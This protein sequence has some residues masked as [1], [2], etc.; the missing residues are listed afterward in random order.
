METYLSLLLFNLTFYF[1]NSPFIE[2]LANAEALSRLQ[3]TEV[4]KNVNNIGNN[5]QCKIYGVK[6]QT[7]ELTN[8][9]NILE[10]LHSVGFKHYYKNS[11]YTQLKT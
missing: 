8:D 10:K 9:N 3:I 11:Y 1:L 5:V 6:Q 7:N 2:K 4:H